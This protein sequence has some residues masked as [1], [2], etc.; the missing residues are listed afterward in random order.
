MDSKNNH[1]GQNI[2]TENR[3]LVSRRRVWVGSQHGR[4]G[5]K[6]TNVQ[7]HISHGDITQALVTLVN[8]SVSHS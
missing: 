2:N 7:L 5:L 1:D 4:S 3:L 8:N 6:G